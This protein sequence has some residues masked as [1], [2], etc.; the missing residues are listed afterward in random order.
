[1]VNVGC[2]GTEPLPHISQTSGTT[3]VSIATYSRPGCYWDRLTNMRNRSPSYLNH[4]L[5]FRLRPESGQAGPGRTARHEID[6]CGSAARL[7]GVEQRAVSLTCSDLEVPAGLRCDL[8]THHR[9]GHLA[10]ATRLPA[11]GWFRWL[12]WGRLRRRFIDAEACDAT[13]DTTNGYGHGRCHLPL[14]HAGLHSFDYRPDLGW[15]ARLRLH[16]DGLL[17]HSQ[18]DTGVP[19]T[20]PIDPHR[21]RIPQQRADSPPSSEWP[22]PSSAAAL[23]C[24]GGELRS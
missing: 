16:H 3:L 14:G 18:P 7:T 11:P 17:W 5:Q 13:P 23:A 6:V 8:V 15:P 4:L 22:G 1:M 2:T 9:R 19:G 12:A 10:L 20:G 21:A 24:G